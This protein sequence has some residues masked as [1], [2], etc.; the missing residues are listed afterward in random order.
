[1]QAELLK[2]DIDYATTKVKEIM[3]IHCTAVVWRIENIPKKWIK[4]LIDKLRKKTKI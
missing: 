4:G 3:D 2:A 1:M